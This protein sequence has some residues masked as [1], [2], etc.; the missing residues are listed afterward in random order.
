MDNRGM[1]N[2]LTTIFL[3]GGF[4]LVLALA[5]VFLSRNWISERLK[6]AIAHEYAQKLET[7]K[8]RLQAEAAEQN[9]KQTRVF[10]D[11]A[12]VVATLY[13]KLLKMSQTSKEL[14]LS[15]ESDEAQ[16]TKVSWIKYNE[17][18]KDL[19]E[20]FF[21]KAIY[22]RK[23][24]A[25]TIRQYIYKVDAMFKLSSDRTCVEFNAINDRETK[26]QLDEVGIKTDALDKNTAEIL[27]LIYMDFQ[28]L[29]GLH[30]YGV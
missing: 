13:E 8:A 4:S 11:Q 28:E 7:Y 22:I 14:I 20:Y 5:I 26:K 25:D 2:D 16:Q 21:P 29:L 10:D 18:K 17:S 24:T 6:N 23:S 1:L 27:H 12:T 30:K 19:A 3:S 9:I 15:I